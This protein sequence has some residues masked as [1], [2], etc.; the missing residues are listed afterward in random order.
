LPP[1]FASIGVLKTGW[2]FD[3]T[4]GK[5]VSPTRLHN[6]SFLHDSA[7]NVLN[8]VAGKHSSQ[9]EVQRVQPDE[10][11][12]RVLTAALPDPSEDILLSI[13]F[14]MRLPW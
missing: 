9:A 12:L 1:P 13:A 10:L 6:L 14:E 7:V 8:R 4:L 5:R 3:V 11:Q 2:D